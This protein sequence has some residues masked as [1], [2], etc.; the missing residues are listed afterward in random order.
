MV[1]P[2]AWESTEYQSR[3]EAGVTFMFNFINVNNK[4]LKIIF[5]TE[6]S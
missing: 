5:V 2:P 6:F 3:P 1:I 4:F